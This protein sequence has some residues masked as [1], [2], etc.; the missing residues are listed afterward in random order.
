MMKIA[1]ILAV[2]AATACTRRV[3]SVDFENRLAKR[4]VEL[5]LTGA[6]VSCPKGIEAK[7][8]A[9]F[10]CTIAVGGKSYE[11]DATVTK[12]DGSELGMDTKWKS[13][14]AVV[15]AKLEP[16]LGKDL[17][18]SLGAPVTIACGEPLR[19]LDAQRKIRCDLSSGAT[20]AGVFITFNAELVPTNW[21][22]DP[23]LLA[24]TKLETILTEPVRAKTSAGVTIDCGKQAF[25]A[26]PADGVVWCEAVEGDKRAKLKAMVNKDLG[27]DSW[28]IP[29]QQ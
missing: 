22:L 10:V 4:T 20:K 27:I 16:M 13:G 19:F 9:S 23:M 18:K 25:I 7:V 24:R 5:G 12:V 17:S 28:E 6:K 29:P 21:E 1:V 14:D 8:G 26:R 2:V 15:S 3:D 11:L